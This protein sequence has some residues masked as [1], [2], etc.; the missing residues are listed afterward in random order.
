[1]KYKDPMNRLHVAQ[2][3][4]GVTEEKTHTH[5]LLVIELFG[6]EDTTEVFL[7]FISMCGTLL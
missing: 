6:M 4:T 3:T 1:M 5:R 2:M 7:L